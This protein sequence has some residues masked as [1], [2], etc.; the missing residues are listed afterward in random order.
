MECYPC[1]DE[2]GT[3]C[4]E[5]GDSVDGACSACISSVGDCEAHDDCETNDY[6]CVLGVRRQLILRRVRH[7]SWCAIY[8]LSHP[9]AAG[10]S[11]SGGS[12]ACTPCAGSG[13]ACGTDSA[14]DGS[15]DTCAAAENACEC[16]A[17]AGAYG[18]C[19]NHN[20]NPG[21]AWCATYAWCNLA[22]EFYLPGNVLI[23]R[24]T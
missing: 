4:V 10:S 23:H 6:W 21:G 2:H 22:Q 1:V 17:S 15:C 9:G 3:T 12:T 14:V 5:Y 13:G 16:R 8:R 24:R 11:I 20:D 7:L 19:A 18:E